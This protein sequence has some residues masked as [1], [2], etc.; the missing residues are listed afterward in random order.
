MAGKV[1]GNKIKLLEKALLLMRLIGSS[2]LER[3]DF[4]K[5]KISRGSPICKRLSTNYRAKI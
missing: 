1:S 3:Q 4:S 2:I 5:V